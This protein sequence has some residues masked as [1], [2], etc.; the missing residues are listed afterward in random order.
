MDNI[1]EDEIKASFKNG[2]L[3]INVPKVKENPKANK[4]YIEIDE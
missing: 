3:K 1:T 4:K 2:I